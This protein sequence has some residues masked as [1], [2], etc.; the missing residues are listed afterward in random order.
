MYV[1]THHTGP[2]RVEVC[3]YSSHWQAEYRTVLNNYTGLGRV[4]VF[5]SSAVQMQQAEHRGVLYP[6][7]IHKYVER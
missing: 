1:V 3:S 5:T 6:K 4:K 2:G 7:R